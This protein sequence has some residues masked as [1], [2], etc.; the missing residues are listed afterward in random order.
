MADGPMDLME[1]VNLHIH[2][3][4]QTLNRINIKI[5]TYIH[6]S[7]DTGNET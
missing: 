1:N 5:P 3:A 6:H 2:K 4:Q 7:K